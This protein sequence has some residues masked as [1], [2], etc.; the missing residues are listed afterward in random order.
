MGKRNNFYEPVYSELIYMT[1]KKQTTV[2]LTRDSNDE[3]PFISSLEAKSMIEDMYR[4]MENNTALYLHSR[5]NYGAN[6]SL[7]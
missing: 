7:E 5:I 3:V 6:R 1:K 2:C 4:L